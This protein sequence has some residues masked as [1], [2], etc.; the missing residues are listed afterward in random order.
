M[1]IGPCIDLFFI[2]V[3]HFSH[4]YVSFDIHVY[5]SLHRSLFH[6]CTSLFT[7]ESHCRHHHREYASVFRRSRL[8]MY[9]GL[10]IGL[11]FIYAYTSLWTHLAYLR[12]TVDTRK[13]LFT[14]IRHF[15][16]TYTSLLTHL[17]YLRAAVDV[18]AVYHR[19]SK[20]V[21]FV[22]LFSYVY[23]TFYI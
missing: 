7:Y 2:C 5:R 21:C 4:T 23:V 1:Y 20:Q 22:G 8:F 10:S 19:E 6:V 3:H 14:C 17:A 12:A 18:R 11:L 9:I 15:S 16:H 13:S